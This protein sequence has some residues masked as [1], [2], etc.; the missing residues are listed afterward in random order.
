MKK[1]LVAIL[2]FLYLAISS[3]VVVSTHY[4]MGKIASVDYGYNGH[5]ICSTCGMEQKGECCHTEFKVVKLQDAHQLAQAGIE[6][7][8]VPVEAPV[9]HHYEN[10]SSL[11][12]VTFFSSYPHAPPDQRVNSIYLYNNVFRV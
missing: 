3:G 11:S 2:A 12:A 8:K 9:Y 10:Y 5:N 1:A 7:M 6:L 4:C